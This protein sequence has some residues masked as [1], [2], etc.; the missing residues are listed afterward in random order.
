MNVIELGAGPAVM[1]I[2]GSP[3]PIADFMPIAERLA[4][5][6]RVVMP[7]L[8]GYGASPPEDD[9]SFAR[10]G[11]MLAKLLV[12]RDC[13]K[14]RALIGFSSGGYRALDLALQRGIEPEIIIGLG[15]LASLEEPDR[16]LFRTV[17]AGLRED[18]GATWLRSILPDR[19]LS[20]GWRKMHQADDAR[21]IA[22]LDLTRPELLAMEFAAEAEMRD[23]RP[24]LPN[25]ACGLYLRVGEL[26][27]ACPPAVSREIAGLVPGSLIEIVPGCGHALLIENADETCERVVEV[28]TSRPTGNRS[29]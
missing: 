11:D 28:V 9:V 15:T 8:P 18:P 14:P 24:L 7:E 6:H 19:W 25:L 10:I 3:T 2:H 29:S 12:E 22:W 16:N 13:A 26:D 1:I 21:V 27:L 17:A 20:A 5:T 4:H 23:L